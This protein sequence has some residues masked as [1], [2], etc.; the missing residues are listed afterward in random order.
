LFLDYT[1]YSNFKLF[2]KTKKMWE[3]NQ[4]WVQINWQAVVGGNPYD[5][6]D[7]QGQVVQ[8]NPAVQQM[9]QQTVQAPVQVPVQT[10]P[11]QVAPVVNNVPVVNP[12]VNPVQNKPVKEPGWFLKWV[13]GFIAKLSGQPD[14]ETW[15]WKA[16]PVA[17]NPVVG[18]PQV[19]PVEIQNTNV[20]AV[21]NPFDSIMWWVTGFLDKVENKVEKASWVNFDA[22]INAPAKVEPVVASV[23]V[24]VQSNV[25]VQPVVSTQPVAPVQEIPVQEVEVSQVVTPA[26]VEVPV[27]PTVSAQPVAPVQEIPAQEIEPPQVVVPTSV[28]VKS[29]EPKIETPVE[30]VKTEIEAVVNNENVSVNPIVANVEE[31]KPQDSVTPQIN[32]ITP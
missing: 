4:S 12:V 2:Y 8:Q 20:N 16:V 9:S 18:W 23:E 22:A 21:Q 13:I 6:I 14:P 19:A 7:N 11:V 25:P 30:A 27:Q 31:E 26:P 32:Q 28:E 15:T 3:Q 29:P 24:P 17:Q 1:L 10:A 5:L